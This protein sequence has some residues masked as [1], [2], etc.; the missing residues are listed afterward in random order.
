MPKTPQR[1]INA[2]TPR[3]ATGERSGV[4]KDDAIVVLLGQILVAWSHFEDQMVS[5][6]QK[7]LGVQHGNL[8]TARLTFYSLVNQQIRIKV[9]RELLQKARHNMGIG[10]EYDEIIDEFAKLNTLRNKYVH[11]LWWTHS[12]GDTH[13]QLDNS[14]FFTH[15]EYRKVTEKE[16]EGF[17]IRLNTLWSRVLAL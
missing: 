9:M 3:A 6:F 17:L 2:P 16:L 1:W 5:V 11:G 7:L 12:N 14:V 15:V 10:G 4:L 8:D 13:L